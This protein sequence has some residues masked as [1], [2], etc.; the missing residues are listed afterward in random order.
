M[1]IARVKQLAALALL[2]SVLSGCISVQKKT[3]AKCEDEGYR[4]Y[5]GK[6]LRGSAPSRK[7]ARYVQ[8][9]MKTAGYEYK[10]SDQIGLSGNH[11]CYQPANSIVRWIY[12]IEEWL[13][14]LGLEI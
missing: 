9:C 10:C 12:Y 14:R 3:T 4:A 1:A 11:G 5:P 8:A 2:L 6:V 7:I 13:A